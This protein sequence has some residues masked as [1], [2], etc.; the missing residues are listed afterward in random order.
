VIGAAL[1]LAL[2]G[3]AGSTA[4]TQ[5]RSDDCIS[6]VPCLSFGGPGMIILGMAAGG[7]IGA[8]IGQQFGRGAHERWTTVRRATGRVGVHVTPTARSG[9]AA[10][11][12]LRF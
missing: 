11:A 8:L 2:G 1:G 12:S 10:V 3:I 4:D 9:V 7:M 6:P 5:P